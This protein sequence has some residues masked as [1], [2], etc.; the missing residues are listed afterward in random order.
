MHEN[1][2]KLKYFLT[3]KELIMR[4]FSAVHI[5]KVMLHSYTYTTV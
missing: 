3:T 4:T 1:T 5:V 2:L